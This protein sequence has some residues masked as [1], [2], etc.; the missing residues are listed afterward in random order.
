MMRG[1]LGG[2]IGQESEKFDLKKLNRD[3]LRE[4][5]SRLRPFRRQVW[6]AALATLV[7]TLVA[8][9]LP[10]LLR[11]GIDGYVVKGDLTG[12]LWLVTGYI[13][14]QGL[15]W[16][17]AYWQRLLSERIGLGITAAM[18]RDLFA[19]VLRQG[20]DF[21][22]RQTVGELMTRHTGD[23]TAVAE[24][25]SSG[26]I[27]MI[28][29]LV[30]VILTAAVMLWLDW[31]LALVGLAMV[32]VVMWSTAA[33]GQRLRGAYAD[34]RRRAAEM[35]SNLQETLAGMRVVQALG[36]ESSS[37]D[38]FEQVNLFNL[39]AN[40]YA[41]LVFA[42]FF[43]LMT[44]TGNLGTAAVLGYGGV[45]ITRGA[46]SLGTLVA[47]MSYIRN[48][49][50][51]LRELSQVYNG[52]QAAA[53][54]LD[55]FHGLMQQQP[56]VA[57]PESPILPDPINGAIVFRAVTF[58]YNKDSAVFTD[59]NLTIAA[60]SKLAVVGA[61][62][63]G[64]TTLVSLLTRFYDVQS[65][66]VEIDGVDV[67]HW[68]LADLRRAVAVV[69]QEAGLFPG[70]VLDNI[71]Y[72][73]PDA[74]KDQ[75]V[76]LAQDLGVHEVIMSLTDGYETLIAAGGAGRVSGGQRQVIAVL[77]AALCDPAIMV[78]DEATSNVDGRTEA[79][80]NAGL[81]RAL[82]GRTGIIIAHRL[83]GVSLADEVVVLAGGKL[84]DRGTHEQLLERSPVYRELYTTQGLTDAPV[85]PR[86]GSGQG[87]GM[88]RKAPPG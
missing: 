25:A 50:A 55:R 43:P 46:L 69:P 86:P 54:S 44:I 39:R 45:L 20:M 37:M 88:G 14:G 9:G 35:G 72:G 17:C 58:G 79:L 52:L 31:R 12:L 3:A 13:S 49:F 36:Q 22:S 85:Q 8:T 65:G 68:P 21:H 81:G 64:K 29:D 47:F 41:M 75:V 34:V 16:W 40:M 51:P 62:G 2:R 63:A 67:R 74:T 59:L 24:V 48:F 71:R 28:A 78:L 32:P 56:A 76:A 4:V 7:M 27:T 87:R 11:L 10:L 73:R 66:A 80:I 33:F 42:M 15:I 18:R 77:R 57:S 1:G 23:I 5:T 38:R 53:A 70:T 82:A 83:R 61:S 26:W 6:L 84:V 19:H 30:G 60:G